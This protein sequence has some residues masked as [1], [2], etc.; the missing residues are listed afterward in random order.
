MVKVSTSWNSGTLYFVFSGES[1]A[2]HTLHCSPYITP[3]PVHYTAACTLHRSLYITPQPVHYTAACT[4]HRSLF[5]TH[6]LYITPQ[7]VH[8]T[9]ACTLHRSLY[10]TPHC[11]A[12]C[13]LHHSLYITPQPVHYTAAC[14]SHRSPYIELCSWK[15]TTVSQQVALSL[16]D[17]YN[18]LGSGIPSAHPKVVSI[19][20]S[21]HIHDDFIIGSHKMLKVCVREKRPIVCPTKEGT[22]TWIV[23]ALPS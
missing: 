19:C 10:I 20:R 21:T 4:L 22:S 15:S 16:V 8:Y 9:A 17:P 14:T 7:P 6:S 5:I 11:T 23:W 12:A 13:T 2:A 3:Q 18:T 1:P